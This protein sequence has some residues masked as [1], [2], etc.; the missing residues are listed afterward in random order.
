[1]Y[2]PNVV[3]MNVN[4]LLNPDPAKLNQAMSGWLYNRSQIKE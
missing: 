3:L 2:A 4:I 1:M